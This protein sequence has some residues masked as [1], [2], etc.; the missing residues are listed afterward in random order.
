[1]HIHHQKLGSNKLSQK[2]LLCTVFCSLLR[3]G[4]E[5]Q[6]RFGSERLEM[7]GKLYSGEAIRHKDKV[8]G[9]LYQC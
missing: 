1:M 3:G 8:L 4:V 2:G 7:P 5:G 6:I 9:M